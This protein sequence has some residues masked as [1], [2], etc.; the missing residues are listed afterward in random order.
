M[1][2]VLYNKYTWSTAQRIIVYQCANYLSTIEFHRLKS[3]FTGCY[4][5]I[6]VQLMGYLAD[7]LLSVKIQ[8]ILNIYFSRQMV[9]L[10]LLQHTSGL[11]FSSLPISPLQFRYHWLEPSLIL[12]QK[13]SQTQEPGPSLVIQWLRLHLLVQDV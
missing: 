12:N 6:H 5:N 8:H 3:N 2:F 10:F 4:S 13:L 7:H 1:F 9:K 11:C